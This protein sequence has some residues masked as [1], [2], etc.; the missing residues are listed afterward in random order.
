[1][2]GK[3]NV[4]VFGQADILTRPYLNKIAYELIEVGL[5]LRRCSRLP[6]YFGNRSR[7]HPRSRRDR[8]E[9]QAPSR[10][11]GITRDSGGDDQ[12]NGRTCPGAKRPDRVSC[13]FRLGR[14][15]RGA[16]APTGGVVDCRAGQAL[17]FPSCKNGSEKRSSIRRSARAP[18]R[19]RKRGTTW[20]SSTFHALQI[21][22]RPARRQER[23]LSAGYC[24][25]TSRDSIAIS[26]WRESAL[27]QIKSTRS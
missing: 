24:P 19:L 21:R 4:G 15:R 16:R 1:M 27:R 7:R 18:S 26:D 20:S 9:Y 6:I 22:Q 25:P 13:E 8:N 17:R 23:G 3:L 2:T 5:N 11:A 12:D 14:A 10:P